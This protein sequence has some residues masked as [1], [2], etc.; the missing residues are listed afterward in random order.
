MPLTIERVE[1]L[2]PDQGSL[3]AARKLF[4]LTIWPTL[5]EGEGLVWGECQ[6]SGATPY[7][8][9]ASESDAGY[10]CT[11]PSRKFPC[12][13]VLALM[14]MRAEG[15]TA[16]VHAAVPDWMKDWLSRRRGAGKEERDTSTKARASIHLAELAEA[17]PRPDPQA[18]ARSAAARERSRIEREAA[19]LAGLEQLDT[20]LADQ[21]ER[22]MVSFISQC[23]Q[24]CRTIAQR[25]VDAKAPGLASRLDALPS[26]LFTMPEAR[27]HYAAVRELGQIHLISQAYRRAGKLDE[28][29]VA[30][31]R[32]TVGWPVTRE[33]LLSDTGAPRVRATWRVVG[34]VI[35]SQPDRLRRVETWLWSEGAPQ[36]A[37][38]IDFVPVSTGA[39]ASGYVVGDRLDAELVFYRSSVQLRAQIAAAPKG[40]QACT[41]PLPAARQTLDQSYSDYEH[42]LARLPW[43]GTF[44]LRFRNASVRRKEESLFLCD[45]ERGIALPLHSSQQTHALPLTSAGLADGIGLWNGYELMLTWADT[46]LGRWTRT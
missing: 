42:A 22:G 29:L 43:L 5:A 39:A 7:R 1:A 4:K 10:K 28:S 14:W 8:V 3:A 40:A 26:L 17:P 31:A 19:V 2:A 21:V 9:V 41:D 46:G 32:Q 30:D 6:G 20:W 44:P 38:L 35:E 45:I 33:A 15:K 13:H 18:E 24:A 27:R 23:T 11:C 37:V 25:L 12:K 34:V 16:F 36:P